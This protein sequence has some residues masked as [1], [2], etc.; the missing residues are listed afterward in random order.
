M[1]QMEAF[2]AEANLMGRLGINDI[3]YLEPVCALIFKHF[4]L[5]EK[6]PSVGQWYIQLKGSP[7]LNQPENNIAK[8]VSS[9]HHYCWSKV[10][11][12]RYYREMGPVKRAGLAKYAADNYK[13]VIDH[14]E[15]RPVKW[16]YLPKL[17]VDYGNALMLGGSLSQS[18]L[19][20]NAFENAL[21]VNKAY[22]PALVVLGN[23]YEKLGDKDRALHYLEE[24]LRYKPNSSFL[25]QRYQ[26][27]GGQL[28]YPDPYSSRQPEMGSMEQGDEAAALQIN[29]V[30][31]SSPL[32]KKTKPAMENNSG[33]V[34][35]KDKGVVNPYCRFCP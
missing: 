29:E 28:P 30:A 15:Y 9:F 4:N 16:P 7:L 10:A 22:V 20:I 21:Q 26:E 18:P 6:N 11:E 1:L 33:K 17:Y 24:G 14:P 32:D 2:G 12:S 13:F 25:K 3:L 31:S 23:A 19:A 34:S 5:L 35:A 27:L 8:G